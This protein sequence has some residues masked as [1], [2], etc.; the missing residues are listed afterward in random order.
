[1]ACVFYAG[2]SLG[3]LS[4]NK[5]TQKILEMNLVEHLGSTRSGESRE[6][7]EI[8]SRFALEKKVLP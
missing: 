8:G 2:P 5:A 6:R 4:S 7:N 3:T 1:M